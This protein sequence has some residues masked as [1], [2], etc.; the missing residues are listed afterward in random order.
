MKRIQVIYVKATNKDMTHGVEG[1]LRYG[2][3]RLI[4]VSAF[5]LWIRNS[6]KCVISCLAGCQ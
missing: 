1:S 3:S 2:S 4:T 6:L 5:K